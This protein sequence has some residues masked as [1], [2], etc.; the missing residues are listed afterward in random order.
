MTAIRSNRLL[1]ALIPVLAALAVLATLALMRS[2][3]PADQRVELPFDFRQTAGTS[4]DTLI[5]S[6]RK[7]QGEPERLRLAHQPCQCLSPES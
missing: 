6:S 5:G 7:N 4:T 3:R 2:E 1:W